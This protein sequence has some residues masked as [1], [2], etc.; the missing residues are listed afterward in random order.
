M[1]TRVI[2]IDEAPVRFRHGPHM[3]LFLASEAG[4]PKTLEDIKSFV[5]GLTDKKIAYVVTAA[6][7]HL[8]YGSWRRSNTLRSIKAIAPNVKTIEL[9]NYLFQDVIKDISEADI[10]WMAG[11]MSGYLLYWIR[12]VGL[13]KKLSEI[14]K[15]T[16]YV[17]SS[18]GSMVCSR[19]QNLCEVYPGQ[20]EVG[21]G[22]IPGLGLIDFEILPHLED[23][24][25]DMIKK[26][27][28]YHVPLYLL[29]NGEAITVVDGKVEILGVE[30]IVKK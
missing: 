6:N 27:W 29:K 4:D 26:M 18:A 20:E 15:K 7:G 2:R 17:G 14:L 21:A 25:I 11:G 13:D 30:R 3:K 10:L 9:E 8:G 22:V 23:H 16:V 19:T 12:R 1:V 5:G 24:N 28:T